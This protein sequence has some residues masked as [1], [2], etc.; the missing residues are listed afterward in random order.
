MYNTCIESLES[1]PRPLLAISRDYAPGSLLPWH[2][3]RRAQLL[4]GATGVMQ[5]DSGQGSWVVPPQQAVWIPAG[6]PHQ[7]RMLGVVTRSLYIL[8]EA[9]PRTS[10]ACEVLGVSPLLRQLVHEAIQMPLL[11]DLQGRDGVLVALIL[12]ELAG[13]S[14]LPLHAPMPQDVRLAAL[15]QAFLEAPQIHTPP[16]QWAQQLH[17]SLRTFGRLFQAQTGLSFQAWRQR[18]CVVHA[19]ACLAKGMAVGTVALE[20]G[21]DSQGAFSSMFSRLTGQPPSAFSSTRHMP[22]V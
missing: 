1:T 6:L 11:Y 17:M 21:Y 4:Y 3:H 13:A 16:Q 8:P 5:V 15:C 12:H 19:M 18:A 20:L 7:V 22:S 10:S 2:S 9:A 14:A